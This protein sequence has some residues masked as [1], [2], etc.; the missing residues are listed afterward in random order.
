MCE[1]GPLPNLIDD[2]MNDSKIFTP[3]TIDV[4]VHGRLHSQIL[5]VSSK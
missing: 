5:Q 1:Q 2:G 3:E 4:H